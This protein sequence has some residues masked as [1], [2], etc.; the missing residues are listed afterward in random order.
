MG[1]TPGLA[2]GPV[3]KQKLPTTREWNVV[4]VLETSTPRD[5][6][7]PIG[8]KRGELDLGNREAPTVRGTWNSRT[9]KSDW[10]NGESW[11]LRTGSHC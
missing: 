3:P 4:A 9:G 2:V 10:E 1:P 11:S 5:G 8:E 6:K 7:L